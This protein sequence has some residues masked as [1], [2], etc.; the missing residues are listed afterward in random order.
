MPNHSNRCLQLLHVLCG[1]GVQSI[2]DGRLL[3]ATVTTKGPLHDMLGTH[4]P[5]DFHHAVA[6]SQ[7][8]DEAVQQLLKWGMNAQL[9]FDVHV[10]F[11][12]RPH[13]QLLKVFTDHNQTRTCR[14]FDDCLRAD[15]SFCEW[16]M[17]LRSSS[18]KK[19]SAAYSGNL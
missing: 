6:A 7:D 9:L 14:K 19:S 11:D 15:D 18:Q 13:T 5:V 4:A 1:A 16:P 17:R 12:D 8:I 3:G 10:R 2:G